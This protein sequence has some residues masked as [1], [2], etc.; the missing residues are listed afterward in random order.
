M[1]GVVDGK[2]PFRWPFTCSRNNRRQDDLFMPRPHEG[3]PYRLKFGEFGEYKRDRIVA[4]DDPQSIR[5]DSQEE[6]PAAGLLLHR[7][8]RALAEDIYFHLA[9][10]AFHP[11]RQSVVGHAWI[12]DHSNGKLRDELGQVREV[13]DNLT[14]EGSF[15]GWLPRPAV[16]SYS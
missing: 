1:Q 10:R 7:L 15:V 2:F 8:D 12:V 14:V 6:P 13:L 16:A 9:H 5:C 11:K 4:L 3:P